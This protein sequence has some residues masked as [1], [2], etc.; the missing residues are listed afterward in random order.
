MSTQQQAEF[1]NRSKLGKSENPWYNIFRKRE[2]ISQGFSEKAH[3]ATG[4]T[5]GNNLVYCATCMYLVRH[6]DPL[7]KNAPPLLAQGTVLCVNWNKNNR[8][9]L[10]ENSDPPLGL[11]TTPGVGAFQN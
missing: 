1:P 3:A 8:A 2:V 10:C 6:S 5:D 11:K 4:L 7:A 9:P